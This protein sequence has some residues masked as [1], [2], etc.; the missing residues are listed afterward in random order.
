MHHE[1]LQTPV[2]GPLKRRFNTTQIDPEV[3]YLCL[4]SVPTYTEPALA[5]IRSLLG[6]IELQSHLDILRSVP[7]GYLYETVDLRKEL[8][9]IYNRVKNGQYYSEY[10][11]QIDI[12]ALF[13]RAREGHFKFKGELRGIFTFT[14]PLGLVSVSQD[15]RAIPEIYVREDIY[16]TSKSGIQTLNNRISAV[17]KINNMEVNFFLSA[18]S[19]TTPAQDPD[20]CWNS[21]FDNLFLMSLGG[22][23][24]FRQPVFYPGR[25]TT[26][27][28]VNGSI[29]SYPNKA[30]VNVDLT[31][32]ATGDD[33]Y[34]KF[35]LHPEEPPEESDESDEP[36]NS[37]EP[38]STIAT[39]I[40]PTETG[41]S[42]EQS[43]TTVPNPILNLR[44]Y[45]SPMVA[46]SFGVVLGYFL[47]SPYEDTAVLS[48][49]GFLP[50]F[51]EL[52]PDD[53][54]PSFQSAIERFLALADQES[55]TNLIIDLQHN[56]GGSVDL[57]ID[58]YAQLFP[59]DPPNA[60]HNM[61]AS[62]GMEII[63]Q[64]AA[65]WVIGASALDNSSLDDVE[66][67]FDAR[68]KPLAW[69]NVITPNVDKFKNFED[70]YGPNKIS[71]A[72]YTGFFQDDYTNAEASEA[73]MGTVVIT[74]TNDRLGFQQY[75]QSKSLVML[76][77]GSCGS[78][79]TI[80]SEY[81]K[82]QGRVKSIALG[83]RPQTG[84]MQGIG[85]TKGSQ[86]FGGNYL[87]II[88]ELFN[89]AGNMNITNHA[90][91]AKGT[92][93]ESWDPAVAVTRS[94]KGLS[95][96]GRNHYRIDD[97]TQTPLQFVYE[98]SD[99]RI[100][101]TAEMIADITLLWERI[102]DIAFRSGTDGVF[103]SE[104]C[105]AGSTGHPTSLS[106]G[107][108]K[109]EIG[110]Q[111]PPANAKPSVKGWLIN[112][113]TISEQGPARYANP[114][115]GQNVIAGAPLDKAALSSFVDE[116][117]A[118]EGDAWFFKLMCE[119]VKNGEKWLR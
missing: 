97:T 4:T 96:N 6:W 7:Q 94:N 19:Y 64:V 79:C 91:I 68:T 61:R 66:I 40:E 86:V 43:E 101:Y 116:C 3:A 48:I 47:D 34:Q 67:S 92:A 51:P 33:M 22:G 55:R 108:K 102:A 93:F 11:L 60:K 74:G 119:A 2:A 56:G 107:L 81:M 54:F 59:D 115:N 82:N 99:C 16:E 57:C 85:A 90:Q 49:L 112:G 80:F 14:R 20:E 73:G 12:E 25:Q 84:P 72:E 88:T 24:R 37:E 118:D 83:G 31:D 39:V 106:G 15:G 53:F 113:T 23:G 62:A 117:D 69:Q 1:L 36:D 9:N 41:T 28:F 5:L 78:S 76:H 63:M 8:N 29:F 50:T 75:F 45:P 52:E 17:K 100:W 98:A 105:I 114:G 35:C 46:D 111:K 87:N 27:E 38:T 42:T 103:D 77:D 58:A 26:I 32:I 110:D 30:D 89:D 10:D 13:L 71:G 109:G 104:Y 18:E 65:A 21:L 95:I 70:Y 44:Y